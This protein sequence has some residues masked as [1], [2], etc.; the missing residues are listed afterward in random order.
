MKRI[1][2]TSE[3]HQTILR[4]TGMILFL[5]LVLGPVLA[6]QIRTGQQ[7]A[8]GEWKVQQL[9]VPTG[10][11]LTLL[12][13]TLLYALSVALTCLVVGGFAG[14]ALWQWRGKKARFLRW[15]LLILAPLPSYIHGLAWSSLWMWI[16][17]ILRQAGASELAFRG[18]FASWWVSSMALLP[19]TTGLAL[20]G[21]LMIDRDLLDAAR[22][23][24]VDSR[25]LQRIALPLASPTLIA[26]S[27]VVFILCMVDYSVPSLFQMNVYAMDIFAEFSASSDPVHAFL[28]GLPLWLLAILVL[29]LVIGFLRPLSLTPAGEDN[30]PA[31]AL[32]LPGWVRAGQ[33]TALVLLLCHILVPLVSQV[34][35]VRTG[36]VWSAAVFDA[37]GEIQ[38]TLWIAL[39]A[40]LFSIPIAVAAGM[41]TLDRKQSR[42]WWILLL[43]PITLPASLTGIGLVT[44]WN[45][46]LDVGIYGTL[47]MPVLAAAARFISFAVLITS[48]QMRTV[49]K[50]LIESGRIYQKHV[51]FRILRIDIPLY[52]PGIVAAAALVFVLT[53]GELGAT[54]IVS[55]PGR[56]TLTMRIYNYLHYGASD[57]V[58]G[59]CLA[60]TVITVLFS[61]AIVLYVQLKPDRRQKAP[62]RTEQQG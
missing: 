28:L 41:Q 22:L 49:R 15:L 8:A 24:S 51:L 21:F 5:L 32:V 52:L 47:L 54:L 53:I 11:R 38:T 20:I 4:W 30:L 26:G 10:R 39:G 46:L 12:V 29:A 2:K 62:G 44:L 6:L 7:L 56:G 1:L 31:G 50:D 23:Q 34:L 16:N 36:A 42:L 17:T 37:A 61:L 19:I 59:L 43:L 18:W 60:I 58:A 45:G 27:G 3:L 13:R 9:L 33:S 57:T 14:C 35:L 25:W 55:P 40:A 48:A